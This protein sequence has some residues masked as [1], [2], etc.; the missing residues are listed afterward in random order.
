MKSFVALD[1]TMS[2]FPDK[3]CFIA[4]AKDDYKLSKTIL[5]YDQSSFSNY[6]RDGYFYCVKGDT[7][8]V[9][10]INL[11]DFSVTVIE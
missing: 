1:I 2:R 4:Y 6:V 10:K 9:Y 8:G 11:E 3:R 7:H 5:L